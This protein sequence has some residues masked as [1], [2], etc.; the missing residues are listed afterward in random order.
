MRFQLAFIGILLLIMGLIPT[1]ILADDR[2]KKSEKFDEFEK[3]AEYFDKAQD[4][5]QTGQYKTARRYFRKVV[6]KEDVGCL[7]EQE[8]AQARI[9]LAQ[10]Y[11]FLGEKEDALSVFED[12]IDLAK[13]TDPDTK[14][15]TALLNGYAQTLKYFG[16][17]L[18]AEKISDKLTAE[19]ADNEIFLETAGEIAY[20]QGNWDKA[21]KLFQKVEKLVFAREETLNKYDR[22][23]GDR[24]VS[25]IYLAACKAK[26]Y[27]EFIENESSLRQA[28]GY[29]K[30]AV[31]ADKRNI[32]AYYWAAKITLET[33]THI[34]ARNLYLAVVKKFNNQHPGICRLMMQTY[35]FES[36]L[37]KA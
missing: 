20:L 27:L 32:D 1:G 8:H 31:Y 5:L 4:C 2:E 15:N 9:G 16:K 34:D 10:V 6:S 24:N 12:K 22:S 3:Y 23:M 21:Q 37:F 18:D 13:L 33:E 28:F 25:N 19:S 26:Y 17:L 7:S 35:L 14:K 36:D 30:K 29:S 11:M